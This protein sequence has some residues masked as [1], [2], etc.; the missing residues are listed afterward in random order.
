MS[1]CAHAIAAD[2]MLVVPDMLK[3]QRFRDNPQVS[4]DPH[5]RFYAGAPLRDEGGLCLGTLCVLDFKPRALSEDALAHLR[6][7]ARLIEEELRRGTFSIAQAAESPVQ[8]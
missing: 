3:D 5:I 1:F 6:D 8:T 4:G 7:L 2:D